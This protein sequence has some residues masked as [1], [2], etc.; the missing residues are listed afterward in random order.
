MTPLPPGFVGSGK[1]GNDITIE[2]MA[3]IWSD[4]LGFFVHLSDNGKLSLS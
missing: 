2:G 4:S 1:D 3:L